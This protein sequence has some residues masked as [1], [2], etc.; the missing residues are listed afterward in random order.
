MKKALLVLTMFAWVVQSVAQDKTDEQLQKELDAHPQQDTVRVNRII[1]IFSSSSLT[2]VEKEKLAAEA[3]AISLKTGYQYG[4]GY[5]LTNLGYYKWRQGNKKEGDSLLVEAEAFAQKTGNPELVG[6]ILYRLGNRIEHTTGSSKESLS[7]YLRAEEA[8]GKSGNYKMLSDF[9]TV[10]ADFY[11]VNL[12]NYPLAMEYL[13]KS[14]HSAEKAHSP[15]RILNNWMGLGTLYSLIGDHANALVYLEKTA[16][17]LKKGKGSKI[18]NAA[19]QTNLGEAFRLS[20]RYSE[21]IKAYKLALEFGNIIDNEIINESNLADVYTRMDSLPLAFQYGFRSL[22][23]AKELKNPHVLDWVYGILAR[24]YL[25]NGMADSSIYYGRLGLDTAIQIGSIEYMRDNAETLANAFAYKKDFAKAYNYQRQFINYKDSMLNAE[26]RNKT[27]LLQYNN[28]LDKKQAQITQ[29]NQQKK[30]QQNFL[31]S[32][33]TVL[34]LIIFTAVLLLRN[35]RQKQKANRLLA[36]QKQEIDDKAKE[37]SVQKDNLQQSYNNVELLGE[38]GHKIS[39]SLS[40]EKIISTVYNNVNSL[41]DANVFGIGIYNK[42]LQ[43]IE[44]PA[45]PTKTGKHFLFIPMPLMI[46][47]A[48]RRFVLIRE[49]K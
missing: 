30:A 40:V 22:I 8:L 20:G 16:I 24:T 23:K 5:A 27:A 45:I 17:E 9:Q 2:L 41:M 43:R 3:L 18:E 35:N 37:L 38:I 46:R 36:K 33:L 29:L 31:I 4:E 47:I 42:A 19:L 39:S 1:A 14:L 13:L 44:F 15:S 6:F 7:Y 10:I 11:Q 28:D 48:L 32:V 12:S 21:A 34:T 25:K 49:K 26:V